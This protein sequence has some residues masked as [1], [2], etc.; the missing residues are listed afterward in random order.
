MA[1][2]DISEPIEPGTAVFPGDTAFSA[3]WIARLER[4]DSCNVSTM[5]MSVHCGTHAD[6][7]SH[8]VAGGADIASVPLDV[9]LGRCRV[10]DV[11]A[12]GEP[13]LVDPAS[14]TGRLEGVERVLL[15]T[16]RR[17]DHRRFDPAF[18]AL[19]PDAARV[20]IAAGV[21]LVG[22][23]TPSMDH[24]TSKDLPTHHLLARHGVALLENLDL[25]R[26]P[27]DPERG[28]DYELVALPL[29]IVGSDSGPVRA[30]LRDL[31]PAESP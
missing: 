4:G 28:T 23:D 17:H 2:Y 24:A 18:T 19:G 22:L 9:Y 12:R 3:E 31:S 16:S 26:V 10:L 8:F 7:P 15:R 14:L 21:R 29:K 11:T 27:V 1:L 13:P 25:G 6:S 30:I 5:R 20:L